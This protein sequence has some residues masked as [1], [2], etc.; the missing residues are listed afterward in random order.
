MRAYLLAALLLT[1]VS[2]MFVPFNNRTR[3][4]EDIAGAYAHLHDPGSGTEI[5]RRFP[6]AK[7]VFT[8]HAT[9]IEFSEDVPPF[10]YLYSKEAGKTFGVCGIDKSVF[11]CDGKLERL[12]TAEDIES[13]RCVVT[14]VYREKDTRLDF[15]AQ[16]IQNH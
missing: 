10:S 11:I 3:I 8:D 4:A 12:I 16:P 15:A 6:D 9:G 2:V 13:G 14:E 7:L 1:L 5:H